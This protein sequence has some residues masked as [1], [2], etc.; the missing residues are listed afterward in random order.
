MSS[1][2]QDL[3]DDEA[4]DISLPSSEEKKKQQLQGLH[5][6]GRDTMDQDSSDSH[7]L[8]K[9]FKMNARVFE[10]SIAISKARDKNVVPDDIQDIWPTRAATSNMTSVRDDGED[11]ARY[12]VDLSSNIPVVSTSAMQ[13]VNRMED[14]VK[15]LLA[16]FGKKTDSALD[17]KSLQDDS[18]DLRVMMEMVVVVVMM[19]MIEMEMMVV[20][21]S[22]ISGA[23]DVKSKKRTD[24]LFSAL[25]QKEQK[26][27]FGKDLEQFEGDLKKLQAKQILQGSE[28]D[29]T[30]EEVERMKAVAPETHKESEGGKKPIA[31]VVDF[32]AD[33]SCP[34]CYV[35]RRQA[36]EALGMLS[37]TLNDTEISLVWQPYL[38]RTI[39]TRKG[40][41]VDDY[42][43]SSRGASLEL[44]GLLELDKRFGPV[45][46]IMALEV[47]QRMTF[48]EGMNIGS[49]K[50]LCAIAIEFGVSDPVNFFRSAVNKQEIVL[51]HHVAYEVLG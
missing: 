30:A 10:K 51:L 40:E 21:V 19:V 34:W 16:R 8:K 44:G 3:L 42:L 41:L 49:F 12:A 50:I 26:E 46:A 4:F 45:A 27:L 5:E 43:K 35:G 17:F 11:Q 13:S 33:P 47:L 48:E 39:A 22:H 24:G 7:K 32:F 25:C 28:R 36:Q 23:A 15:K 31:I 6:E 2:L 14:S 18:L 29:R 20:V 38:T 1:R 37:K 9:R